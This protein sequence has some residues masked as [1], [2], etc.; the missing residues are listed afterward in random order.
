MSQ[1]SMTMFNFEIGDRR[2][3]VRTVSGEIFEVHDERIQQVAD[4]G[5]HGWVR[6]VPPVHLDGVELQLYV[7]ADNIVRVS[8]AHQE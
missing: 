8:I 6:V 3:R 7:R 5:T 2:M 4:I 1:D